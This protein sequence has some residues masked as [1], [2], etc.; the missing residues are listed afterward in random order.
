MSLLEFLDNVLP[1]TVAQKTAYDRVNEVTANPAET[2]FH[3]FRVIP[4]MAA[5]ALTTSEAELSAG[6]MRT[7]EPTILM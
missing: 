4:S 6:R 1:T 2:G 7:V 3:G 5:R